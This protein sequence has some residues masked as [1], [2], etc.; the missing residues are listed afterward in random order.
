MPITKPSI[1]AVVDPTADEQPAAE[2]AAWLAKQL[3]ATLELF[4]CRYDSA[5]K[6]PE[7]QQRVIEDDLAR[8]ARIAGSLATSSLTVTIDARW[9]RPLD[10]G[11]VRKVLDSKPLLVT[12]D[13][14]RHATLKQTLFSNTD[15]NLIRTCPAPLLF[16]KPGRTPSARHIIAAVD[17]LHEHDKAAELDR[18]ILAF[19]KRL[20]AACNGKLHVVHMFNPMPAIATTASGLS[21]LTLESFAVTEEIVKASE[22]K[23]RRALDTLLEQSH[24]DRDALHFQRGNVREMLPLLAEQLD[25]GFVVLGAIARSGLSR[26]LIGSTAEQMLEQ[27]PCDV[28][29]VKPPSF[30]T[31]VASHSQS[32]SRS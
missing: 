13:T 10:E 4:I 31:S 20:S 5:V 11:I 18:A 1:L 15:W 26:V 23:H 12:K 14:H 32:S 8:L 24:L 7:T 16:V 9:D 21:P 2:R 19:A 30:Q 27:L 3:A 25:A 28:I 22:Q 29:V 17:P 6:R